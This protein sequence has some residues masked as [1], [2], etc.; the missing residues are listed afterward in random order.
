[1]RAYSGT[2]G[3]A[4]GPGLAQLLVSHVPAHTIG[5]AARL[6]LGIAASPTLE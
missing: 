3:L 5:L 4:S 6:A 1:M 2:M